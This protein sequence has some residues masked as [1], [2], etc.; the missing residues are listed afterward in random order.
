[1]LPM[2][3]KHIWRCPKRAVA[4]DVSHALSKIVDDHERLCPYRD[5][6]RLADSRPSADVL[7]ETD[8]ALS[9]RL[10]EARRNNLSYIAD[11]ADRMHAMF[12]RFPPLGIRLLS[13]RDLENMHQYELAMFA[14]SDMLQ[15]GEFSYD[16]ILNAS[17][18]YAKQAVADLNHREALR[19][20]RYMYHVLTRESY[21]IRGAYYTGSQ[22]IADII[23]HSLPGPRGYATI[24]HCEPRPHTG[25]NQVPALHALQ[26]IP[27][28]RLTLEQGMDAINDLIRPREKE[29]PKQ[30]ELFAD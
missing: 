27:F 2:R 21:D 19:L 5:L 30:L 29:S 12:A 22:I 10:E 24:L 3:F 1:M 28:E 18:H 13:A 23:L 20:S 15:G 25:T 6:T 8:V 17:V 4:R 7:S 26:E 9:F 14:D 11:T 16:Q